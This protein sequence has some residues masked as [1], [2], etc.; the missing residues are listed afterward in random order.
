[1]NLLNKDNNLLINRNLHSGNIHSESAEIA[2]DLTAFKEQI[3]YGI[4]SGQ[5]QLPINPG[6]EKHPYKGLLTNSDT[7]K[8]IIGTFP[9][10][11]YLIDTLQA[12]G[13]VIEQ[14]TQ[15]TAPHQTISK[16]QIPFFH[17]NV[18]ALWS[19]LLTPAELGEMR[20]FLPTNR[21][22]ARQY[23]I[24]KLNTIGVYY[25]D[26]IL[27]TQR[28]LGGLGE[29]HNNLGYTYEDVNLKNICPDIDLVQKVLNHQMLDV[30]CFTNGATF[31]SGNNGGLQFYTQVNRQ[32]LIKT[33]NADALSLFLRT[34]QDLGLNIEMRC[35]PFFDWTPVHQ[36]T[37][38]QKRTKLI[39]EL[40]ISKTLKITIP[41]LQS[42]QQKEF[43][44]ITPYSPAAHGTIETHPIVLALKQAIG[45]H[46]SANQLLSN[47]YTRF[48]NNTY[49]ELYQFNINL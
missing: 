2:A 11:S 14:L 15:P 28:K 21:K 44:A 4:Q 46:L 8:Y 32:G 41:A 22:V 6:F 30:V 3:I 40:R 19:V 16:P 26:V 42:F 29:P 9:P 17:G 45:M 34:C 1:M 10:I 36:L 35:L 7:P 12:E 18:N 13:Q 23:L 5:A 25:D 27:A 31:R 24:D 38:V 49:Q 39:F 48:R 20:G 47:I 43:T 37:A 33:G